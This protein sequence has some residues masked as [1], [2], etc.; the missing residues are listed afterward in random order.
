M[1]LAF[2]T[3]AYVAIGALSFVMLI[4]SG[5][6]LLAFPILV[7][8]WIVYL[9]IFTAEA[10]ETFSTR[11]HRL[12]RVTTIVIVCVAIAFVA[13]VASIVVGIIFSPVP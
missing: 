8:L 10:I 9:W 5:Q 4:R 2:L 7:T 13:L 11:P 6:P 1:G 12:R 3:A